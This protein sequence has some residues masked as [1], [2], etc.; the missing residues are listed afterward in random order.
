MV[1]VGTTKSAGIVTQA[2]K[3]VKL[4]LKMPVCAEVGDR[5]AISR[6]IDSRWRLIGHGEIKGL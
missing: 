5:V 6:Q 1:N 4:E 2:G 3:D